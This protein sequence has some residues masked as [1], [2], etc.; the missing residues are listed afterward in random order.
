[1]PCRVSEMLCLFFHS[2]LPFTTNVRRMWLE[3]F[4]QLQHSI[5]P[6]IYVIR[7]KFFIQILDEIKKNYLFEWIVRANKKKLQHWTVPGIYVIQETNSVFHQHMYIRYWN[8]KLSVHMVHACRNGPESQ[9]RF[10]VN[11][12]DGLYGIFGVIHICRFNFYYDNNICQS[13]L[14]RFI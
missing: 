2:K 10:P 6:C 4:A 3:Y 13:S 12:I 11:H 1:M 8:I 14:Q 9:L 5:I 7:Q